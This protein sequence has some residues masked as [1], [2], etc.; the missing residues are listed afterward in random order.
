MRGGALA[1]SGRLGKRLRIAFSSAGGMEDAHCEQTPASPKMTALLRS[2][3]LG[4]MSVPHF[5]QYMMALGTAILPGGDG[6]GD[7]FRATPA[8]LHPGA[9]DATYAAAA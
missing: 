3:S 9:R 5:S 8:S 6:L 2:T 1:E 7:P 4:G